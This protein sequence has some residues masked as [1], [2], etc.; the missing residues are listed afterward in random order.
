MRILEKSD[1]APL[2]VEFDTLLPLWQVSQW[3]FIFCAHNDLRPAVAFPLIVEC[4]IARYARFRCGCCC[5]RGRCHHIWGHIRAGTIV[6][7]LYYLV[8]EIRA[9]KAFFTC[10]INR[11]V[12]AITET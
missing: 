1:A 9:I 7:T 12:I 3:S 4:V 2:P 5:R 8:S 6:L 11:V 10:V